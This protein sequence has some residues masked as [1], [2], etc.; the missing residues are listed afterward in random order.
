MC[1]LS[2]FITIFTNFAEDQELVSL[3]DFPFLD[4]DDYSTKKCAAWLFVV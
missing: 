1:I 3:L 4:K 2:L